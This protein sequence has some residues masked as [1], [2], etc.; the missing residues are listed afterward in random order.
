M[1]I[2]YKAFKKEIIEK[3]QLKENRFGFEPE[4]T[5]KVSIPKIRIYEVPGKNISE[6]VI[7][8]EK[9]LVERWL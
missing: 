9:K 5:A 3:I 2:C 1:E 7:Q 4:I 6:E 8:K